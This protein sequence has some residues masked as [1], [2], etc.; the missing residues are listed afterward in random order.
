MAND[1]SE[2][3]PRPDRL[4]QV[5]RWVVYGLIGLLVLGSVAVGTLYAFSPAAIRHP[6]T[7]H[8][9]FRLQV[10]V[11]GAPV[12]FAS[13]P[14]QTPLG[15]DVCT[16]ALTHEPIHFHDQLDQFVHIH[17]AHMTGGLVLK[18]YGWNLIS[19]ADDTLGYRFD[20]LPRLSHVAIHAPALPALPANAH[21]FIYTGSAAAFR[22]RSWND[23]L[24]QDLQDFFAAKTS[25]RPASLL[26]R[27]IP[28][29]L[30]HGSEAADEATTATEE[31]LTRL[32]N[33]IGSAVV[34]VQ[35]ER[36]TNAQIRDRFE[37]LVPLPEST[38]GG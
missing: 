8:Y 2:P 12:N 1:A 14:F 37:H 16:A 23:F 18:N 7:A 10:L 27:L 22:E 6:Q 11:N 24:H 21:F 32:N 30:A 29:A 4:T 25:A 35:A 28:A 19:G 20:Q 34:F 15:T 38:C 13:T 33:V 3:T 31:Q 17:W 5:L 26:D 36:P 9:H